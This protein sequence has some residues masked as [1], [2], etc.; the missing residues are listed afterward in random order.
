MYGLINTY[1]NVILQTIPQRH[2]DEYDWLVQNLGQVQTPTYQRKFSA[3]WKMGVARLGQQYMNSF[4]T[5]LQIAMNNHRPTSLNTILGILHSGG[6]QPIQ[7]SFVTK[8]LHMVNRHEPI[9][10]SSVA[11]FYFYRLPPTSRA[12]T[13]RI[14]EFVRFYDFL[15]AEYARVLSNGL[16]AQPIRDFYLRFNPRS[17]TDEKVIDSLIWAYIRLLKGGA[18]SNVAIQYS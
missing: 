11:S 3:Y 9:F 10:D 18:L 17:F 14:S 8:L 12:W 6:G 4:F 5:Q 7:F 15:R 1:S 2:V 13:V 16:L